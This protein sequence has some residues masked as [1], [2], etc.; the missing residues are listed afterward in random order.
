MIWM[1]CLLVIVFVF[2]LSICI[3]ALSPLCSKLRYNLSL[4]LTTICQSIHTI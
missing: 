1:E 3:V 4:Y 2:K